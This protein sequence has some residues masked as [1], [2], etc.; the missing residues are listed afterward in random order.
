VLG[1]YPKMIQRNDTKH[2]LSDTEKTLL[3]MGLTEWMDARAA[4]KYTCVEIATAIVKLAL[5]LQ[6]IQHMNQFMYW[7]TFDWVKVVLK[8]A[9]KLDYRAA[10]KGT[11]A[12][13]PLYCSPVPVKGTV[14][15]YYHDRKI[16]AVY[17][18]HHLIYDFSF[19]T[20]TH[21]FRRLISPHLSDMRPFIGS[22]PRLMLRL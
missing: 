12:I 6:E 3:K 21:R 4:G 2:A 17:Y 18:F 8:Q 5:Y 15:I 16:L 11:S 13:A 10:K 7:G 14:C 9:Q 22:N 1:K 19:Q 20:R